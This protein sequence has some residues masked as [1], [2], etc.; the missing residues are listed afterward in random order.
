MS[1]LMALAVLAVLLCL[2]GCVSATA[3]KTENGV[4]EAVKVSSFL[5]T[6]KNGVYTNGQGVSL[7][8]TDS[9]PDQQSIAILSGALVDL[10]KTMRSTNAVPVSTN[11]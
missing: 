6:I 2:C 1:S 11:Q 8:V 5:S 10:V 4:T 3:T 9:S 7:S